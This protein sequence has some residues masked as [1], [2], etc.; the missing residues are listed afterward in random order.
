MST[1]SDTLARLHD[2]YVE[3]VNM[4]VAANDMD[5]VERLVAEFDEEALEVI[6]QRLAAA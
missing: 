2:H 6:R 1:T 3:V 4:A 5:R